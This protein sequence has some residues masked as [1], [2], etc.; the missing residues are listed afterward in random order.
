V[1]DLLTVVVTDV[2]GA[3]IEGAV[4]QINGAAPSI[5]D[6]IGTITTTVWTPSTNFLMTVTHP[7]FVT[8]RVEFRADVSQGEWDN[9]LVRRTVTPTDVRLDVRL[10]RCAVVPTAL[11][12]EAELDKMAASGGDPHAALLFK[13]PR[14]PN[15]LAYRFQWND[16]LS[17][18]LAE[19]ILLP[20]SPPPS[21]SVGW[22]RF[23]SKPAA[24]PADVAALGRFFWLL[25]PTRPADPQYVVAVWSPNINADKPLST[26]DLVV[27]FSPHTSTYSARYPFGLAKGVKPAD[28]QYLSLGKKYLLEEYGFAY[29]LIA[30]RRQAVIVMPICMKG[31]WGPFSSQAGLYRLCREVV[32]FLHRECRTSSLAM[33][34]PGGLTPSVRLAGGSL[35]MPGIGIW[36]SDFGP[37]PECGRIAIS[38]FSTG[39][40]AVKSV[41]TMWPA[42][43][44]RFS[45]RYFGCPRGA[46]LQDPAASFNAS[47]QELWDLDGYHPQTGGWPAYLDLLERWCGDKRIL[48]LCHSSGRVPQNPKTDSHKLWKR[49]MGEGVTVDRSLG[50]LPGIGTAQ[51]LHGKRWSVVSFDDEY[52][53]T[54]PQAGTPPLSDAHHATPKVA[55]SHVTALSP[56]G[57]PRK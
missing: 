18:E 49:L 34:Q 29:E 9:A 41:M 3:P 53:I 20:S 38:G 27:F 14:F 52:I 12:P 57:V 1:A 16:A 5:T 11:V 55:F 36:S 45:E 4:V 26:I 28:Q 43:G 47:F 40:A 10:G 50:P 30:R 21:G 17:V 22:R 46:N 48:R 13:P 25:Y 6:R 19:E 37:I 35:R 31:D 8:E 32:L 33:T 2:N 42:D 7:Y 56:I 15:R 44:R 24:P 54:S 51:E 39:I 23:Q